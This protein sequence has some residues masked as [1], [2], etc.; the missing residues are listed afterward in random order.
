MAPTQAQATEGGVKHLIAGNRVR[1]LIVS[2]N[3]T[4]TSG[5]STH[6]VKQDAPFLDVTR[7]NTMPFKLRRA[8]EPE[9]KTLLAQ[10]LRQCGLRHIGLG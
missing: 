9:G 10:R 1:S 2:S 3:A 4:K 8:G 6:A 5:W 7:L